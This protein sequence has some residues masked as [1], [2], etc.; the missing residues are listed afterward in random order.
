MQR[1]LN[2]KWGYTWDQPNV[3]RGDTGEKTLGS[4]LLQSMLLWI[5]PAAA[6][7]KDVAGFCAPGGLVDRM[8]WAARSDNHPNQESSR[9]A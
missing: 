8:I 5:V 7:G 1:A 2:Q 4:Q 3:F 6:Q 9:R